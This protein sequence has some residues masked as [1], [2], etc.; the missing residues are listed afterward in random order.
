[1]SRD[2]SC[3]W[4]VVY[5]IIT[6]WSGPRFPVSALQKKDEDN[7]VA[8]FAQPSGSDLDALPN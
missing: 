6:A 3:S 7:V 2:S 1:M 8:D 5:A 4:R